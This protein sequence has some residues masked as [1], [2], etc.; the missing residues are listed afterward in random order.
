MVEFKLTETEEKKVSEM[1]KIYKELMEEIKT[2]E[3][4]S[5]Y[6]NKVCK[7]L[8]FNWNDF[9]GIESISILDFLGNPR[10]TKKIEN[11]ELNFTFMAKMFS[12]NDIKTRISYK[13]Y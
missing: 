13:T 9:T 6:K 12:E 2:G 5:F 3:K 4:I 1:A 8:D 11:Q 10:Y 7:V